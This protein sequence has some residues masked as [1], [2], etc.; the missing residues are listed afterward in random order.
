MNGINAVT[1]IIADNTLSVRAQKAALEQRATGFRIV[2]ETP[3]V[4][5]HPGDEV[6]GR[7]YL[8]FNYK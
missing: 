7:L 4:V 8:L 3:D 2:L 6:K 1:S 5:Y